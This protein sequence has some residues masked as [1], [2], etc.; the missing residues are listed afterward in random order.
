GFVS[1]LYGACGA[2]LALE[3]AGNVERSERRGLLDGFGDARVADRTLLRLRT[4]ASRLHA[5]PSGH[6][7]LLAHRRWGPGHVLEER[8]VSR[9]PL[10]GR[11]RFGAS[12]VGARR[13]RH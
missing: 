1:T 2:G 7:R 8:S 13:Y 9:Q 5:R 11:S 12:A 4:A 10:H 3:P 6:E